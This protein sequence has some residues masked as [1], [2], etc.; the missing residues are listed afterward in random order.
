MP[1]LLDNQEEYV[2]GGGAFR[3]SAIRPEELEETEYT[4]ATIAVD[5]TG[6][7]VGYEDQLLE[8]LRNAVDACRKSPRSENLLL[9]VFLFSDS[10]SNHIEELHGFRLL[11]EID[12]QR[13]YPVLRPAGLTPLFDAAYSAIGAT[14]SYAKMLVDQDFSVNGVIFVITDGE[15]NSSSM[16]ASAVAQ[17]V[18]SLVKNEQ[19]EGVVTVLVGINAKECE[20]ALLHF[21]REGNLTQYVD[22]GDV[23]PNSLA[24]LAAFISRSVSTTSQ[25]LGTGAPSQPLSF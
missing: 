8:M 10:L 15:D 1:R 20:A 22:A 21:K 17:K 16:T 13:D 24:K 19:V 7:V 25:N 4:L 3:F 12:T 23:T 6:S 2:V 11:R 18:S 14:E 9:R 5:V